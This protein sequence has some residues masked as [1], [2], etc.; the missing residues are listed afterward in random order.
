MGPRAPGLT[1]VQPGGATDAARPRAELGAQDGHGARPPT[2][3][4]VCRPL[5]QPDPPGS[6]ATCQSLPLA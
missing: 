3:G 2:A 4:R 6:V 5:Y 1:A